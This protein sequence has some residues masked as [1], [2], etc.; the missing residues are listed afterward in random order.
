MNR[1]NANELAGEHHFTNADIKTR[2]SKD[3]HYEQEIETMPTFN[4]HTWLLVFQHF[5]QRFSDIVKLTSAASLHRSGSSSLFV[6]TILFFQPS[7]T[8]A[9]NDGRNVDRQVN[10]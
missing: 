6:S 5:H 3:T 10:K 7:P 4:K 1:I 9:V 2:A 8:V